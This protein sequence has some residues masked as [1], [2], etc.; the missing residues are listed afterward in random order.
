MDTIFAVPHQVSTESLPPSMEKTAHQYQVVF[1]GALQHGKQLAEV[2]R[3]LAASLRLS[4]DK[5]DA[6]FA[7]RKLTLKRTATLDQAEAFVRVFANAGAIAAVETADGRPLEVAPAEETSA[8]AVAPLRFHPFPDNWLFKPAL[9]V[10]T[11]LESLLSLLHV[12]LLVGGA[13]LLIYYTLISGWLF[14]VIPE[15]ALAALLSAVILL[16][17]TLLML[18]LAKP[19]LG[20]LPREELTFE[21]A[22]EAE[23]EFFNY[24]AE[25]ALLAGVRPPVRIYVNNTALLSVRSAGGWRGWVH[26]DTQLTVGL[27]LLAGLDSRQLAALLV[28]A[29]QPWRPGVVA[30]LGQLLEGNIRWLH[31]AGFEGDAVDRKLREWQLRMPAV[32]PLLQKLATFA[33]WSARPALWRLG[34]SRFLSRRLFHRLIANRDSC[35]RQ[36]AGNDALRMAM[37]RSR[38]LSFATQNTLPELKKLWGDKGTLPDN[39]AM[40]IV[41][42]ASHYPSQIQ[43]QL[44][45][46]EAR[47]SIE[48]GGF[49]PASEQRL[50]F[51]GAVVETGQYDIGVP[52]A[53]FFLRLEKLMHVLTVRYYHAHLHIPVTTN[54]LVRIPVKGSQEYE[55]DLSITRFFGKEY[56]DFV[57]LRLA[58]Q[59][60]LMPATARELVQ[61]W[62]EAT[63]KVAAEQVRAANLALAL[64]GA[65]DELI[66]ISNRELLQRAGVGSALTG[67]AMLRSGA[68]EALHQQCRD[69]E[70]AFEKALIEC[71]KILLPY[72]QRLVASLAL[73]NCAE[74]RQKMFDADQLAL[75]VQQVLA[76]Y[77][78]IETNYAKLRELRLQVI[79]L[80]SLLSF[81][82]L[83][84]T[85]KLRDRIG[86]LVDDCRRSLAA[87]AVFYKSTPFPLQSEE[88]YLNLLDWVQAQSATGEI[89]SAE[90]DRANDMVRRLALMQRLI[91]GRLVT[92]ALHVES[93]MGLKPALREVP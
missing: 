44:S 67:L 85:A 56:G 23:P 92:I 18:L 25:I 41:A 3:A 90:F 7:G 75:E 33:S 53:A 81:E 70:A 28:Q 65:D 2:K 14:E 30:V 45:A 39:L 16:G 64:K 82:A 47:R 89:P 37:T 54:K 9:L 27:A 17:G 63:L 24:V 51:A 34:F 26:R 91:T 49:K 35:A 57:P 72:A 86:E 61:R 59:F 19:L 73:L 20:L 74:V 71:D 36:V 11:L 1:S 76:V 31:Q 12:V 83:K 79:L 29:L 58:A 69:S 43:L 10:A 48:Q 4:V 88:H 22:R 84:S 66:D 80:E 32:A 42:R 40:A 78:K 8:T 46:M 60:K 77:E 13:L 93:V 21:L 5:A 55:T 68:A 6:L 38:L 62:R 87:F 15:M 52:C 50:A